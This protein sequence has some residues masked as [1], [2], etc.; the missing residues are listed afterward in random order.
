MTLGAGEVFAGFT[1]VRQL[2]S[3][4]M[5]EVYLAQHPRLPRQEALK[6]VRPDISTD[7]TFLQRF[8]READSIAALEHP[9]IVTVHDQRRHRRKALDHHSVCGRQ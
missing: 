2:G 5:G 7:D 9:N 8:I 3:G 4:G 1:I 6:I